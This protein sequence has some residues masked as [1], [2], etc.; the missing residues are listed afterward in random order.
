MRSKDALLRA[1]DVALSQ[2]KREGG[3][4]ICVF[5]QQGYIYTPAV[6]PPPVAPRPRSPG[7]LLDAPEPPSRRGS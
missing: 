7:A 1:A 2:A 3:A 4:R 5:Q 6:A